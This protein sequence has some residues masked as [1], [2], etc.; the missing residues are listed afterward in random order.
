MIL[1][2]K[3]DRDIKII[4]NYA[5]EC[6]YNVVIRS[7]GHQF[8]GLSS[9]TDQCIQI[10]LK[11][12]NDIKFNHQYDNQY[13][14]VIKAGVGVQLQPL[15]EWLHQNDLFVPGGAGATTIGI[16]GHFQ[17][18]GIGYLLRSF[19]A[20]IDCVIGFDIILANGKK[21]TITQTN[22]HKNLFYAVRGGGP[23][24]FGVI[25]NL[26]LQTYSNLDYI[27]NAMGVQAI[28]SYTDQDARALAK[29]WITIQNDPQYINYDDFFPL[30]A[31]APD[32]QNN[33]AHIILIAFIWIQDVNGRSYIDTGKAYFMQ[34]FLDAAINKPI[35][36]TE[37]YDTISSLM[38]T[39]L[40]P[41]TIVAPIPYVLRANGVSKNWD[42][43][44]I[45][46]LIDNITSIVEYSQSNG[47]IFVNLLFEAYGGMFLK[48]DWNKKLSALPFRDLSMLLAI[49]LFYTDVNGK[50]YSEGYLHDIFSQYISLDSWNNEDIRVW[51]Y[52]FGDLD[53]DIE[54]EKL[55]Y[56]MDR[57]VF[58]RLTKIKASAD[59]CN[60]F[61]NKFT[62]P[63]PIDEG[64]WEEL[65]VEELDVK[66]IWMIQ[67]FSALFYDKLDRFTSTS[68]NNGN[69]T[70]LIEF[71]EEKTIPNVKAI[72]SGD[73]M[74]IWNGQSAFIGL[75]C[76]LFGPFIN[77]DHFQSTVA[78]LS[79]MKRKR[80]CKCDFS[81]N[82]MVRVSSKAFIYSIV[83][84][85]GNIRATFINR[86]EFN[87]VKYK[88]GNKWLLSEWK[89]DVERVDVNNLG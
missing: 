47:N 38:L 61:K 27:H 72:A 9:C 86:N 21:K 50:V 44:F 81:V 82:E 42:H 16:G 89:V 63:L 62:V 30:F 19:G 55:N 48:N 49:Q 4:L 3:C 28:W 25:T 76:G 43:K 57:N 84:F 45:D 39:F 41:S 58:N 6:G 5:S 65:N 66:D 8:S 59:R 68:Q 36:F 64:N 71:I 51:G 83:T 53:M 20:F 32:L 67:Q 75:F 88:N 13:N 33:G 40:T 22:N 78:F 77:E 37:T 18:G 15:Y 87:F 80:D 69:C 56:F 29:Q 54:R 74:G 52:T 17:T 34:Q 11:N 24:S 70:D 60:L 10:D 85:E 23:G 26:Y 2:A 35:V 31:V 79:Y 1:I 12:Y 7:G 46:I 14:N 73:V